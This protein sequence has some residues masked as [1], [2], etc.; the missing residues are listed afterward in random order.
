M[1]LKLTQSWMKGRFKQH[2]YHYFFKNNLKRIAV[3]IAQQTTDMCIM[4]IYYKC[5]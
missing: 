1:A 2:T 3:R 4:P 5:L